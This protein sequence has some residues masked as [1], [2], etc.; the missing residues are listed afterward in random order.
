M[1]RAIELLIRGLL[2]RCP[3]CGQGKLFRGILTMHEHCPVCG[4]H[5]EREEGYFTASMAINIVLSEIIVAAF[6]IPLAA[7][8]SIPM[9]PVLLIGVPIAILL[10]FVFFRHSRSLWLSMDLMIHPLQRSAD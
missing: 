8:P 3:V 9:L 4:Y 10:P 2:L 1:S 5:Y 6:T 7:N